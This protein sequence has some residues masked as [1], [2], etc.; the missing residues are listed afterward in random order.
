M[1]A[2]ET[3][4]PHPLFLSATLNSSLDRSRVHLILRDNEGH[5]G[6]TEINL[7]RVP[8]LSD[9]N[10]WQAFQRD[11]IRGDSG[12]ADHQAF[13][14]A[15]FA[16]P[17]S[18]LGRAFE[19]MPPATFRYPPAPRP[20]FAWACPPG[21]GDDFDPEPHRQA[22]QTLFGTR[23]TVCLQASL[24]DIKTALQT[25]TSAFDF[26][27]V[28]AHGSYAAEFGSV[29]LHGPHGGADYVDAQRLADGLKGHG[30]RLAF[31]CSCQTAVVGERTLSGVAQQLLAPSAGDLP[32]VVAT[33]ANL[34]VAG[35]AVLVDQFY[36]LLSDPPHDPSVALAR[37]RVKAYQ[38]RTGAWSVPIYLSRPP[39]LSFEPTVPLEPTSLPPP[40]ETFQDR[41]E[42]LNAILTQARRHRLVSIVGLPGIGKTELGKQAARR[43]H[44]DDPRLHLVYR[45]INRT[46]NTATLRA[47]VGTALGLEQPPEDDLTLAHHLA[48]RP[49]LVLLDNAEDMMADA[50]SQADFGAQLDTWLANAPSLRLLL[51][52]R[53]PLAGTR[54]REYQ[55]D[56]PPMSRQQT[57]ALL[58]DELRNVDV[59]R[60]EWTEQPEWDRLLDFLDGHPRSVWLVS[61]H[62]EGH[63]PS[64]TRIVTRLQRLKA[65]AVT[66]PSLIGRKDRYDK[67]SDASRERMRSLVASI[68]FSFDVLEQRHPDAA[69]AFLALSLFP[70]GLPEAVALEVTGGPDGMALDHLYRYHL[71]EWQRQRT[72][73]PI[74][75]RWYAEHRRQGADLDLDDYRQRAVQAYADYAEDLN[76]ALVEQQGSYWLEKWLLEE[77]TLLLLSDWFAAW[78]VH[79]PGPSSYLARIASAGGN[80]FTL[81]AHHQAGK[82]LASHGLKDA[83]AKHDPAG[84]A[85]CLKALGDLALRVSD[86][87]GARG[88]YEQALPL[89]RAIQA[90][91]GE[92]NCLRALGDLAMRVSDLDGA[93]GDYEQAL[94]LYRAIQ[95]RLGEANCLQSLALLSLARNQAEQ[96]FIQFVEVLGLHRG[97]QDRLGEQAA[98]GYLARTAAALGRTDQA[99]VL[100]GRSLAV[101]RAIGDRFGQAITL[102]LIIS[103]LQLQQNRQGMIAAMV[104]YRDLAKVL[105]G[106]GRNEQVLSVLD[107][108]REALPKEFLARLESEGE[109]MLEQALGEAE[110]RL[111]GRDPLGLG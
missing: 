105:P 48:L 24:G 111:A 72:F 33:Q 79:T 101:G 67:L 37:A 99:L 55:V 9:G 30:I 34:P 109:A 89:Y 35:S 58:I 44:A 51:T 64:L 63:S 20:L 102:G 87:D 29:A 53:W 73:Y 65:A 91:L 108:L 71:M 6:A 90:R 77:Q 10:S 50:E 88:D 61:H 69:E 43:L 32:A 4:P 107:S 93:R 2:F 84:E 68:D 38:G 31:L 86:L 22:L 83:R 76:R 70:A 57:E 7:E 96:A 11:Y 25:A 19:H 45:E 80:F 110:E 98:L 74:P 92:A 17:G 46:F 36:R 41:P 49:T 47:L 78:K 52:T 75:L 12:E 103:L 39:V 42:E 66:D 85:N 8:P 81:T 15:L 27:H 106:P 95:D 21:A 59:F 14:K 62:F 104:I 16:R 1:E 3:T 97:L 28:L 82:T 94:P 5:Q 26:L 13:G 23:L 54:E 18:A 100:A 40:R 56:I 60:P